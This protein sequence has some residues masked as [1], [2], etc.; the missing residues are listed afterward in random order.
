MHCKSSRRW[1]YTSN[2]QNLQSPLHRTAINLLTNLFNLSR[3]LPQ[4]FGTQVIPSSIGV[5][6]NELHLLSGTSRRTT[7]AQHQGKGLERVTIRYTHI[8]NV[9]ITFTYECTK[10]QTVQLCPE[11]CQART[12]RIMRTLPQLSSL[13][14]KAVP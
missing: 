4:I 1:P 7:T 11:L 12:L 9:A 5:K 6:E 3:S 10:I 14:Q 8:M 13:R 2:K